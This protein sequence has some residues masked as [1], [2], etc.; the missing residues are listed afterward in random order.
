MTK[1]QQQAELTKK[2]ISDTL[3]SMMLSLPMSQINLRD[4]CAAAGVSTGAFYH[5]FSS[6]EEALLYCYHNQET[7]FQSVPLAGSPE[8]NIRKLLPQALFPINE[9]YLDFIKQL[10]IARINAKADYNYSQ[11]QPLYKLL[12]AEVL[13]LVHKPDAQEHAKVITTK[14]IQQCRGY[15]YN[16]CISSQLPESVWYEEATNELI[17]YLKYC[18]DVY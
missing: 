3:V 14:L 16:L 12:Y 7:M 15:N 8:E 5:H 10:H 1:R 18:I 2:K 4:L 11:E 6:K 17:H 9:E 13:K